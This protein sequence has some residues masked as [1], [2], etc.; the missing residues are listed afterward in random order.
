[1]DLGAAPREDRL[2]LLEDRR[3]RLLDGAGGE[4]GGVEAEGD[5]P[6]RLRLRRDP[7]EDLDEELVAALVS[8]AVF[9]CSVP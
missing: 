7:E 6:E 8:G 1:M 3:R 2:E 9:F 5:L 4:P